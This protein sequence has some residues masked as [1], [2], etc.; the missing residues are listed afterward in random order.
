MIHK[1]AA[2]VCLSECERTFS[3]QLSH[4]GFIRP[5]CGLQSKDIKAWTAD[6]DSTATN[7]KEKYDT[8]HHKYAIITSMAWDQSTVKN[9]NEFKSLLL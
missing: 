3:S 9:L 4:T 7:Q 6:N 1:Q 8:W 5:G 2:G